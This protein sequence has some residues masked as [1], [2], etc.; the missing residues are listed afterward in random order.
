MIILRFFI[1][2]FL[3]L[4]CST[5]R[6]ASISYLQVKK[7]DHYVNKKKGEIKSIEECFYGFYSPSLKSAELT[8]YPK[9]LC[10]SGS[11]R[12][13]EVSQKDSF[14]L[15]FTGTCIEARGICE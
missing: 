10:N 12:D 9:K 11:V 6:I 2:L 7:G 8:K 13:L 3:L 5:N 1:L 14:Y 15:L 4:G